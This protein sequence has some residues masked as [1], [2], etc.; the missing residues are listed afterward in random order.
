VVA[1]QKPPRR[2]GEKRFLGGFSAASAA[3][4]KKP[5]GLRTRPTWKQ[6]HRIKIPTLYVKRGA[7]LK[8][9][10]ATVANTL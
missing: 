3:M 1:V 7:L 5:A 9:D 6:L 2:A 4:V 10:L 8:T